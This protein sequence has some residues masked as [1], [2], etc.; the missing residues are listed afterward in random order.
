[1]IHVIN[2]KTI[3]NYKK[4]GVTINMSN[5]RIVITG[6]GAVT[7]L[8]T[9]VS[10]YW[11]NLLLGQSGISLIS[12]FDPSEL[13]VKIAAEVKDFF[14]SDFLSK[15]LVRNTDIFMQFALLAAK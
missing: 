13:P 10:R 7:P 4:L 15:K 5:E 14:P 6:M 2:I 12:R 9:G 1:M 3:E 11:R 8:G